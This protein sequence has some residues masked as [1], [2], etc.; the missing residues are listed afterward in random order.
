MVIIV[1][2]NRA[3]D[4][5]AFLGDCFSKAKVVMSCCHVKNI[6]HAQKFILINETD[7]SQNSCIFPGKILL[8]RLIGFDLY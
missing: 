2:L 5:I 8:K 6:N 7:I 1:G 4:V 3:L